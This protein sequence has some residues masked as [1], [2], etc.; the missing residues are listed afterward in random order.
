[1]SEA[2]FAYIVDA[3]HLVADHGWKLLPL[4]RFDPVSG[5][6]RHCADSAE[7]RPSLSDLLTATTAAPATAPESALAGQLDAARRTIAAAE[8]HPPANPISSQIVSE[9]FE[10]I[11]WFPLPGEALRYLQA[12]QAERPA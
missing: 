1:M 5:L 3:V 11:R 8:T 10:R 9:Q 7:E 12:N 6:W 2:T 4:Y